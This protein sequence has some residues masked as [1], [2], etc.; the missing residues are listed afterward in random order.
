MA[1]GSHRRGLRLQ[2]RKPHHGQRGAG[3]AAFPGGRLAEPPRVSGIGKPVVK[4]PAPLGR[5]RK[6]AIFQQYPVMKASRTARQ[7]Q[8]VTKIPQI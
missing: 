2:S 4:P 8:I 6:T 7:N 3:G 1:S 5:R